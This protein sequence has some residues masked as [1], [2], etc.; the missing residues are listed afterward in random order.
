MNANVLKARMVLERMRIPDFLEKLS[1]QGCE[2]SKSAF[3]RKMNGKS[4]FDRKEI[5]AIAKVLNLS[6]EEMMEIFFERKV[7]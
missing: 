3:H 4:E 6:R 1:S 7:S 5:L 2:M